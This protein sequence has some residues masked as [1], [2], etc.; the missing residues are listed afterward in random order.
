MRHGD[1]NQ[2]VDTRGGPQPAGRRQQVRTR[3]G[4]AVRDPATVGDHETIFARLHALLM[5]FVAHM[6]SGWSIDRVGSFG[7]RIRSRARSDGETASRARAR[8]G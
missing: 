8:L 6:A 3:T 2:A 7:R 1:A 5:P 4:R